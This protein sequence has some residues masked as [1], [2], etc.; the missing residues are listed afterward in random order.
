MRE[1]LL[2]EHVP[3]G[4][5]HGR[6]DAGGAPPG[7]TVPGSADMADMAYSFADRTTGV[8]VPRQ[9]NETAEPFN[10]NRA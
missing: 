10:P 9:R 6:T 4:A 5:E 2:G 1:P 7:R 3:G 8:D